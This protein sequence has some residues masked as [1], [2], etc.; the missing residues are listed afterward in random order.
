MDCLSVAKLTVGS[1]ASTPPYT[2]QLAK[3]ESVQLSLEVHL[4]YNCELRRGAV[5]RVAGV[6]KG[7]CLRLRSLYQRHQRGS[8]STM[9]TWSLA[10]SS[11]FTAERTKPCRT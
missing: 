8:A 5:P 11:A 3:T 10:Q 9:R 2:A 7:V 6:R 1:C 4:A